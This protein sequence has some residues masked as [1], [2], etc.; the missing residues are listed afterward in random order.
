MVSGVVCTGLI[1]SQMQLIIIIIII[2]IY[3]IYRALT[4]NGPKALYIIKKTT[5]S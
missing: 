2:I 1:G 3:N 4:P 5:K